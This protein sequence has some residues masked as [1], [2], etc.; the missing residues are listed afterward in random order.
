MPNKPGVKTHKEE[1]PDRGPTNL[2]LNKLAPYRGPDLFLPT[3]PGLDPGLFKLAPYQGLIIIQM[4]RI[5]E[6]SLKNL[7][8]IEI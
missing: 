8:V 5:L 2:L 1:V 6:N 4:Q 3:S 7:A